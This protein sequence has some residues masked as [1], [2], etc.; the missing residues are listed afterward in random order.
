MTPTALQCRACGMRLFP[1]RYRCCGCGGAVLDPIALASGT[2]MA[3]THVH[4]VPAGVPYRHLL[5]VRAPGEV[6]VMAVSKHEPRVG[7]T[8]TLVQQ[9]DQAIVALACPAPS[10]EE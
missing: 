3:V 8:V 9:E 4:R 10:D 2:V 5:E 1:A 7:D 6:T